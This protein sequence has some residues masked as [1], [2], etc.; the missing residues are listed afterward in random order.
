M[1]KQELLKEI[2]NALQRDDDIAEDM[3]LESIEEWDS[4][5][6]LT[7]LSLYDQLFSVTFTMAEIGKCRKVSD[8]VAL[9]GDKVS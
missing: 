7:L 4:L 2:K 9:V 6:A 3:E 8:L 5:A 1:T